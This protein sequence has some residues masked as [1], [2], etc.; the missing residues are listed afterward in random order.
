MKPTG[1]NRKKER[2][3]N[4]TLIV[5]VI[6][7]G[8][9]T[10]IAYHKSPSTA[11]EGLKSGGNLFLDILPAM[12]VAFIAAGMMMQVLPRDLLTQWLGEESGLRGLLI[13]TVAGSF[14]PGGPFIQ[15]PIVAALLKAGAGVGPVMAY[16]TSWSL[17]GVNRFFVFELPL[18]GFKLSV[19]RIIASLIFPVVIGLLTRFLW[20][21]L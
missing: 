2:K 13:A 10:L 14:T 15:F 7:A 11:L 20:S 8:A 6:F 1:S 9:L 4:V 19:S 18:L 17:I 3:V 12:G 16:V 21:R 5:M